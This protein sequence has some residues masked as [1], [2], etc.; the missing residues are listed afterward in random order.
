MRQG[1]SGISTAAP[2]QVTTAGT[3]ILPVPRITLASELKSHTRTAPPNTTLEYVS[4]AAR[5]D[6][7][8]PRAP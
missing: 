8:P 5:E 3:A 6:P 4:A 1:D 2:T 7:S